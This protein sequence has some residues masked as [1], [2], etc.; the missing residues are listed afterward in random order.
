[1]FAAMLVHV[2]PKSADFQ[3]YGVKSSSRLPFCVM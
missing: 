1:M 3:T 2:L